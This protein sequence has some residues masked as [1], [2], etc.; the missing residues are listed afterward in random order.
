MKT[1]SAVMVLVTIAVLSF[2]MTASAT[3]SLG[4]PITTINPYQTYNYTLANATKLPWEDGY[5]NLSLKTNADWLII[6]GNNS[7]VGIPTEDDIGI[8]NVNLTI[9]NDGTYTYQNFTLTV[10]VPVVN[11]NLFVISLVIP[12]FL[13]V[14]GLV[15]TRIMFLSGLSWIFV[16]VAVFY[17]I[18]AGWTVIGLGIGMLLLI[19]GGLSIEKE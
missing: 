5:G 3:E 19:I 6:Q 7:I 1:L 13:T 12:I 11:N 4:V 18:G 10:A 8:Y 9:S 16:S 2:S 15:E 17:A 14:V